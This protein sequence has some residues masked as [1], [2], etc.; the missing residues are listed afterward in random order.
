MEFIVPYKEIISL[1]WVLSLLGQNI[2]FKGF[3]GGPVVK[4]PAAKDWE[5]GSVPSQG[6]SHMLWSNWAHVS[7]W[8]TPHCNKRNHGNEKPMHHN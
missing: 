6:E 5:M 1:M 7:Q 2:P 8:L 4:T 3:P